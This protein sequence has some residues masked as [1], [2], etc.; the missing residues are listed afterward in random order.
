MMKNKINLA[1]LFIFA[2][3]IIT[4]C[5]RN[6]GVEIKGKIEGAEGKVVVLESNDKRIKTDTITINKN[7]EFKTNIIPLQ[8]PEFI[9]LN[10]DNNIINLAVDSAERISIKGDINNLASNYIIEGSHESQKIKEVSLEGQKL[11]QAYNNYDAMYLTHKINADQF[12]DSVRQALLSYKNVVSPYIFE[13]PASAAAYFTVLQKVN[14]LLVFDPNDKNDYVA[15]A[16]V[17]TS[18]DTYNKTHTSTKPIRDI[19][20]LAL[21]RRRNEKI[22]SKQLENIQEQNMIEIVLPNINEKQI[23]LSDINC[24]VVLLD[25]TMYGAEY[26]TAYDMQL[27][28]IYNKFKNKNFEIYQVSLDTDEN[29]WKN[30][31]SNLPWIT[32]NDKESVYSKAAKNSNVTSLPTAYL[33]DKDGSVIIRISDLNEAENQIQKLL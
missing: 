9:T 20:Y 30:A 19:V 6:N 25:F 14:G 23:K 7:G 3:V 18:W 1:S 24:K 2:L 15:Y 22:A 16:A 5:E 4:G 27:A 26:T 29:L 10:I 31:A 8:Y 33:H 17:A 28:S 11:K 32:V 13:N 21:Q 12:A